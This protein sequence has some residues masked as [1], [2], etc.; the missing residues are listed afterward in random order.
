MP[1][2]A[3]QP[4][5]DSKPS[6]QQPT[7]GAEAKE[8]APLPPLSAKEFRVYNRLAEHMDQFHTHFRHTYATLQTACAPSNKKSTLPPKALI[9]LGLEFC[10]HLTVHHTIEER[11]IFPVLARRMP[12]FRRELSLIGQHKVIHRGMDALE[13][14]LEGCRRGETDLERGE[15]KR[16]L[17]GFGTVLFEHLDEEVD[18]LRA[19]NMRKYWALGEMAGLPM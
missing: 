3:A 15:V 8:E 16:L 4:T 10:H 6:E 5:P 12:E 11:H 18:A 1:P 7:A 19:E 17:E 13:R 14:Y 2:T 9:T